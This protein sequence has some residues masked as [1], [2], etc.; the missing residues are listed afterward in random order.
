MINFS[1]P[2]DVVAP[3][4]LGC[5]L[6]HAGVSIRLTEIEAYLGTED[7]ASHTYRGPTPRNRA[8]FSAGGC[9]YV[10]VSYGIHR[11][12]NIVCAPQGVGQ[13]CLLRAGEI[14]EG[15]ELARQRRGN[16]I[17]FAR[18]AQGPGNLG[19]A[20]GLD[21]IHNGASIHGP[22]FILTP[23]TQ[24]PHWVR[25]PRIGI[26]KNT[27]APLRFWI[28]GDKTVSSPRSAPAHI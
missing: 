28:P 10:Y 2:A 3:Q 14:V 24:Q 13:G 16:S 12:G 18:L 19:S 6:H 26:S 23:R 4:L 5:V 21:L 11:A 9:M 1:E 22:D 7:A 20:L 17:P 25:G 27:E 8:M 15:V